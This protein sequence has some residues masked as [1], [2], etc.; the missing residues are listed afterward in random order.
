MPDEI[1]PT[2]PVAGA[3]E[4]S[5]VTATPADSGPDWTATLDK[6]DPKELRK[7]PR[8]SGMIG[9]E[10]D[11]AVRAE[12]DRHQREAEGRTQEKQVGD[13]IKLY[14]ENGNTLRTEYPDAYSHL[15]GLVQSQQNLALERKRGETRKEFAE[16]IGAALFDFSDGQVLEPSELTELEQAM[17]NKQDLDQLEAFART[18]TKISV[19]KQVAAEVAKWKEKELPKERETIRK[20]E[21]AKLLTDSRAPSARRGSGNPKKVDIAAMSD[22]EFNKYWESRGWR[23]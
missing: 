5:K 18:A 22:E 3:A 8:V 4:P 7:H 20:E 21:A 15:S 12:R 16:R 13:L 14:E 11:R 19:R 6:V 2:T 23:N 1:S 9:S 10:I 17:S